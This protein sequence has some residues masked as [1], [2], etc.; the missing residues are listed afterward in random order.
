MRQ[1]REYKPNPPPQSGR[2]PGGGGASFGHEHSVSTKADPRPH[3]QIDL[4]PTIVLS[5][6]IFTWRQSSTTVREARSHHHVLETC[7]YFVHLWILLGNFFTP[8]NVVTPLLL[9]HVGSDNNAIICSVNSLN[10]NQNQCESAALILEMKS[11]V[12]RTSVAEKVIRPSKIT[13]NNGYVIQP[14]LLCISYD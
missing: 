5:S 1:H 12:S 6:S 7:F 11:N 2:Y 13:E 10:C 14:E 8:Q 3:G 4:V 9:S